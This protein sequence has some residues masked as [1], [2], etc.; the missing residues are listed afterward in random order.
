MTQGPWMIVSIAVLEEDWL[1]VRVFRKQRNEFRAAVAAKADNSDGS[2][3]HWISQ[4]CHA[5]TPRPLR[6]LFAYGPVCQVPDDRQVVVLVLA[7]FYQHED[8]GA[9]DDQMQELGDTPVKRK[10]GVGRRER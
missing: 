9:D 3:R 8:P 2:L 7:D 5:G 6:A 4:L 1:D 10:A